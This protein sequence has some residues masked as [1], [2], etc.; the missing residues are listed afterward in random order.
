[1][2]LLLDMYHVLHWQNNV[3]NPASGR[4]HLF[5]VVRID[6]VF[7]YE[8]DLAPTRRTTITMLLRRRSSQNIDQ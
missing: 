2:P 3:I 8:L 4:I 7:V 1:M 5:C 6:I